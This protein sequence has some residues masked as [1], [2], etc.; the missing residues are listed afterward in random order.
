MAVPIVLRQE[1]QSATV[2]GLV[3][4]TAMPYLLNFLWAP[5]V[6]RWSP[7]PRH[8]TGWIAALSVTHVFSIIVLAICDPSGALLPMVIVL[9]VAVFAISTQDV[10]VDALAIKLLHPEDRS[11][12]AA[13]PRPV[14]LTPV[15]LALAAL[16]IV[17]LALKGHQSSD[18]A[19][20]GTFERRG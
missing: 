20:S 12:G 15:V 7:G 11:I 1:G 6:D 17:L 9:T 4:L 2:I 14:F 19:T 18:K 5:L 8:Y 13:G 10:A 3:Q 16:G